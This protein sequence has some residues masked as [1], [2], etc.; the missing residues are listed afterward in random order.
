[1]S[2][3][4]NLVRASVAAVFLAALSGGLASSQEIKHDVTFKGTLVCHPFPHQQIVVRLPM[5]LTVADETISFARPI[6]GNS[7]IVGNEVAKGPIDA[8]GR[9]TLTSNGTENGSHYEGKYTGTVAGDGGTFVGTQTWSRG[10]VTHTRTCTGA[11][12]RS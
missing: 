3:K 2:R 5:D 12:V 4:S 9:F 11:F 7:Q 10:E 6:V 8:D 1:M